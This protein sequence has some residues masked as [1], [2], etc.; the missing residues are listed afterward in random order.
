MKFQI[1]TANLQATPKLKLQ[2]E[3]CLVIGAFLEAGSCNL[4]VQLGPI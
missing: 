4:G 3:R 2:S 1:P